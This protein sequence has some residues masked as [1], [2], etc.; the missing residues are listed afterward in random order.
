MADPSEASSS[1]FRDCSVMKTLFVG[2]VPQDPIVSLIPRLEPSGGL[3]VL[4]MEEIY[5]WGIRVQ[6]VWSSVLRYLVANRLLG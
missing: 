2:C 1:F 4:I 6:R 5:I 3:P